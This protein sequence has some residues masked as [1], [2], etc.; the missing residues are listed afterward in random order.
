MTMKPV[1]VP[2]G[3]PPRSAWTLGMPLVAGAV[4]AAFWLHSTFGSD[5]TNYED[6]ALGEN[7]LA[8]YADYQGDLIH[9]QD[10]T[11]V[12]KVLAGWKRRGE[13]PVGLMLGNSQIHGINQYAPGQENVPPLLFKR[14]LPRGMDVLTFTQPSAS[15]QEHYILFEYLRQRFPLRFLVLPTVFINQRNIDIRASVAASLSDKETRAALEESAVGRHLVALHGA[16]VESEA[17]ADAN[18]AGVRE[19]TAERSERALNTW[20]DKRWS[21]WRARPQ[22][23]GYVVTELS[24]VR[25]T[26]LGIS[27]ESKRGIVPAAYEANLEALAAILTSAHK[28]GIAVLVYITPIRRDIEPP[29]FADEYDKFCQDVEHVAAEHHAYFANYGGLVPDK[30]YGTHDSMVFGQRVQPDFFHFQAEAHT[31]LAQ[32][33]GDRIEQDLLKQPQPASDSASQH[34]EPDPHSPS[35]LPAGP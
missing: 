7:T 23:R 2:D 21:L 14:C 3:P 9:G 17:E 16:E 26:L 20:L 8:V 6:F 10:H 22:E 19:T 35:R 33:I 12:D 31:I 30:F 1:A 34:L 28:H 29:Y 27:G 4:L 11:N 5:E 32:A 15:L 18:L 25:N 13:R 24:R